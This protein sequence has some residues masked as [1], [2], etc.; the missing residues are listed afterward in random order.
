MDDNNLSQLKMARR[1]EKMDRANIAKVIKEDESV[2]IKTLEKICYAMGA[3]INEFERNNIL[4]KLRAPE[5][6]G[7]Y[8]FH[9]AEVYI[10][11]YIG[12]RRI[13]IAPD[14]EFLRVIY[15]L[16][17]ND[18]FPGLCFREHHKYEGFEQKQ[19]YTKD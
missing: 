15:H 14:C 18:E 11:L 17:W 2:Q 5:H 7:H 8:S 9:D 13:L 4:N 12:V 19:D 3:D 10:G 16:W 1:A 6:L